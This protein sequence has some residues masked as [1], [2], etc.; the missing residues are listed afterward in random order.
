M[1]A[2]DR[3][4]Y[5]GLAWSEFLLS[6]LVRTIFLAVLP[7]ALPMPL[8]VLIARERESGSRSA[9][10]GV[11]A[12]VGDSPG[13]RDFPSRPVVNHPLPEALVAARRQA[14]R[15]DDQTSGSGE[16]R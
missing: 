3:A 13:V 4:E 10:S 7:N 12:W 8:E 6:G 5:T 11:P 1:A 9:A 15:A 16:F 14:G 2:V